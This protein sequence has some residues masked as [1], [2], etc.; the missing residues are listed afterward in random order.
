MKKNLTKKAPVSLNLPDFIDIDELSYASDEE[1]I[2]RVTHLMSD[3]DKAARIGYDLNPWEVEICYVQREL[4]IRQD[5]RIAHEKFLARN[6]EFAYQ[7]ND[8]YAN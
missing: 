4:K 1:L 5:R 3:R 6:G 8:S 7:H 2:R